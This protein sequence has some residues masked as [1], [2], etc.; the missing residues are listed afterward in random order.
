VRLDTDVYYPIFVNKVL[1]EYPTGNVSIAGLRDAEA[2]M[3]I[4][5]AAYASARQ[6]GAPQKITHSR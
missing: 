3:R 1:V 4:M 5:D 2:M 6:G